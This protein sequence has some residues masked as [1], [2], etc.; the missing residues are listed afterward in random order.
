[1]QLKVG[2]TD[3]K[4]GKRLQEGTKRVDSMCAGR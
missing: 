1:M 2:V 3:P 4:G